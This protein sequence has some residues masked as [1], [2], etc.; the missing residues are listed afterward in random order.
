VPGQQAGEQGGLI[1]SG[2]IGRMDPADRDRVGEPGAVREQM[3]RRDTFRQRPR[4][5]RR[6]LRDQRQDG[7]I[8]VQQT[9]VGESHRQ[10]GSHDLRHGKP[11][12]DHV[13]RRGLAVGQ[14]RVPGGGRLPEPFGPGDR[15]R[16]ARN[17]AVCDLT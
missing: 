5:H 3:T 15:H 16:D 2:L 1:G 9:P 8:Q 13:R 17:F 11:R 14:I 4:P 10:A 12:A 6:Q 7:L